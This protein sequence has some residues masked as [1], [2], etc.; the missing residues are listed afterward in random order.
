MPTATN[1]NTTTTRRSAM[2]LGAVAITASIT[3][4]TLAGGATAA[5]GA[6]SGGAA[7][8]TIE[9]YA[10]LVFD[11]QGPAVEAAIGTAAEWAERTRM[12]YFMLHAAARTLRK[13][14]AAT[15]AMVQQLGLLQSVEY[16][17][18]LGNTADRF[19]GLADILRTAG[20]R[21]T[22]AMSRRLMLTDGKV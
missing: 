4:P 15:L 12:D 10:A 7:P 9:D 8:A 1:T 20:T 11:D 19:E 22:A 2:R 18:A 17:E 16:A 6:D 21:M 5:P 13:D 14:A 3:A